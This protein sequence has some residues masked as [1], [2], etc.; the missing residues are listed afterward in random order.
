VLQLN[1]DS[2]CDYV[3][4]YG[5]ETRLQRDR[6]AAVREDGKQQ[7]KRPIGQ[8]VGGRRSCREN[9]R[10]GNQRFQFVRGTSGSRG[11][12]NQR[13]LPE[14]DS[15]EHGDTGNQ[16]VG[17][18]DCCT[19]G[20]GRPPTIGEQ[21]RRQGV[22]MAVEYTTASELPNPTYEGAT[23]MDTLQTTSLDPGN[24]AKTGECRPNISDA[25]RAGTPAS[26]ASRGGSTS[27]SRSL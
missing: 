25:F 7:R 5:A 16:R 18:G 10:A 11:A 23:I 8:W 1:L 21:R 17:E 15:Q 14:G 24:G 4:M 9:W 27:R 20:D 26:Q 3:R 12:G 22:A 6:D 13:A 2:N 19:R